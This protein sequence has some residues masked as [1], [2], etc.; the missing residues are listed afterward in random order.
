M[1]WSTERNDIIIS[2]WL[3]SVEFKANL[4]ASGKKSTGEILLLIFFYS[5][6]IWKIPVLA[7][8]EAIFNFI[9]KPNPMHI[10]YQPTDVF[11][12]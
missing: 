12:D 1:R 4:V 9:L 8:F 7:N 2:F 3:L 11:K 5:S 10:D 6:P